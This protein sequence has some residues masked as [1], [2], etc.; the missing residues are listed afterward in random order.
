[1]TKW[2]VEEHMQGLDGVETIS[3]HRV[4]EI[5]NDEVREPWKLAYVYASAECPHE[6]MF[7]ENELEEWVPGYAW[8]AAD[9]SMVCYEVRK[10]S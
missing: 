6:F 3:F 10:L 1:V 4:V 5:G 9:G 7:G 2:L 8:A